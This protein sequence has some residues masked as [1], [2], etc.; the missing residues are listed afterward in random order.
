MLHKH[1]IMLGLAG[2]VALSAGASAKPQIKTDAAQGVDFANC[3]TYTWI[4]TH[5]PG[6]FNS[7]AYQRVQAHLDARLAARDISSIR[8]PTSPWS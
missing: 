5:P 7:V 6:G 1:L 3:K 8:R 2:A 4:R